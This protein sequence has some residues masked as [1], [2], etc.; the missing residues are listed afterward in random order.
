M[1]AA[2]N[3]ERRRHADVLDRRLERAVVVEDLNALVALIGDVDVALRVGSDRMRRVE[4][5]LAGPARSPRLDEAAVLVEL[6]D[7]C[8]GAVAVGDEDVSG[9]VPG[10]VARP[11][12]LIAGAPRAR[13]SCPG[14]RRLLHRLL[15]PRPLRGPARRPRLAHRR[16][17]PACAGGTRMLIASGLRPSTISDAPIGAEL[18]DLIGG[19]VDDPD[20]VLRVNAHGV[21]EQ[22]RVNALSQSPARRRRSGRTRRAARRRA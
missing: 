11:H 20:V 22:K 10:D 12:E 5:A 1:R 18:Q 21:R 4:F 9:G 2:R 19:L 13:K 3:A 8:V 14:P 7:A 17:A 6:R 15:L 16:A